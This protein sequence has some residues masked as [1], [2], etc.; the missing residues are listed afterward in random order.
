MSVA[1]RGR[2]FH[3]VILGSVLG[4]LSFLGSLPLSAGTA[5]ELMDFSSY[6]RI[7]GELPNGGET[8]LTPC[9]GTS[10]IFKTVA[11]RNTVCEDWL[12]PAI[13]IAFL[14]FDP[15]QSTEM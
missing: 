7:T 9:A 15:H 11:R 4:I 6:T 1:K 5:E 12:H 3:C 14:D 10:V 13:N 2:L 8:V